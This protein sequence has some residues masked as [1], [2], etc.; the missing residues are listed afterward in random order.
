MH[1]QAPA[2]HYAQENIKGL[3]LESLGMLAFV[4]AVLQHRKSAKPL[5]EVLGFQIG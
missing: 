3:T 2:R 5:S 4:R 1:Y